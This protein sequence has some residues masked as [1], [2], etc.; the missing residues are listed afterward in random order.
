VPGNTGVGVSWSRSTYLFAIR[1]AIELAAARVRAL[2]LKVEAF[3]RG[4]KTPSA[5][6]GIRGPG[7][8]GLSP[9]R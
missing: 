8:A 9:G 7:A 1:T 3:A 5:A 2:S 4:M 6:P